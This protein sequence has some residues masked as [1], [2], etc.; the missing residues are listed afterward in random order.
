M[1]LQFESLHFTA[2]K[3]LIDYISKKLDKLDQFHDKIISGTVTLRLENT[4]QIRDKVVEVRL[5]V[6]GDVII[7]KKTEKSFEAAVDEVCGP[8]K[9]QLIKRKE[10][11]R[12]Y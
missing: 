3:K 8:L 7:G 6:P 5:N 10:I 9:R 1:K 4:G 11:E 2:D 12:A